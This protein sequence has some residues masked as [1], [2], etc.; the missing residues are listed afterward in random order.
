[1]T[2]RIIICPRCNE[3]MDETHP[4]FPRCV[5]CGENLRQCGFCRFFPGNGES[6]QRAKGNPV[7]YATTDLNCPY[8]VPKF[9]VKRSHPILSPSTRWQMAASMLF[10]LSVLVVAFLSR[11]VPSRVLIAATAPSQVIVGDFL[12]VRMLVK[13]PS[14]Q[15]IKVRLDRV[16]MSDFQLVGITPL[17]I[18]VQQLGQFYEFMLPVLSDP[19]PISVKFKS[20]KVGEYAVKATIVTTPRNKVEWQTKVKVVKQTEP[21]RPAKGLAIIA[22]ALWR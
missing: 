9:V 18:R 11:P 15:P 2:V 12:E 4:D 21:A 16:L 17:P 19:Q 22:M 3:W 20:T 13:A 14:N 1:M 8:F 6:C 10:T 5:F 7:V